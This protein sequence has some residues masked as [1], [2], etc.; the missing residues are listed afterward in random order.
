[1]KFLLPVLLL[2][3]PVIGAA[4][5]VTCKY[6]VNGS[7]VLLYTNPNYNLRLPCLSFARDGD[8]LAVR[9]YR[10]RPERGAA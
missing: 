6:T 9:W 7:V 3:S 2:V 10:T 4:A 8:A 5:P 1:M